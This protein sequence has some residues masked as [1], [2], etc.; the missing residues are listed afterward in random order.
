MLK[1]SLNQKLLQKLSPQQIQFV[2]LL[3]LNTT[4]ISNKVDEE[5]AENGA[6][7]S[8]K[9]DEDSESKQDDIDLGLESSS[10]TDSDELPTPEYEDADITDYLG[11]EDN[12][13]TYTPDYSTEERKEIPIATFKTLYDTLIEQLNSLNLTEKQEILA[14]HLIG[15]VEEDGYL[16][17]PL[18]SI[19]YDLAFLNSVQTNEEELEEVLKIIQNLEPIG[20][21]ARNLQECLLLQLE[22]KEDP[23]EN[24][25]IAIRIV[26]NYL[27]ELANKHYDKLIKH[28][29]IDKKKLKDVIEVIIKL[30]PKPGESQ[31]NFK[32][33]YIIP[34]FTITQLSNGEFEISLN[35][36]NAPQLHINKSFQE[37]LQTFSV[38]KKKSKKIRDELQFIK[39]KLDNAKW[40][41]EAIKQRQQTLLMTMSTIVELQKDFFQ[42]GDFTK[43]K[44]MILKDIA[45]R[46]SMD[47]S[48]VSRVVSSKYTQTDFGIFSLREFFSEGIMKDDGNEVSNREVK[49]ILKDLIEA[50]SKKR[51]LTD[52]KLTTLLN[53]KGY[54]I[55]RR[56]VAKYREQMNIPVARL[57]KEL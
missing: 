36:H 32:T 52:E 42:N 28:L 12:Y 53:N 9:E 7:E 37:K 3:Q 30:N 16:R 41:I 47:I 14:K 54:N 24:V 49:R 56:T 15:M 18:K 57:R 31:V 27:N 20:I 55:A 29:D 23:S 13:Q 8:G 5:L 6:L 46:I 38:Q 4:E 39:S 48:T 26:T 45:D 35:S 25:T 33:Q 11:D 34:D 2:Q 44:P 40:F 51:P 21:A 19:S 10:D 50:E 22:A 1:Q 43:L 17:R